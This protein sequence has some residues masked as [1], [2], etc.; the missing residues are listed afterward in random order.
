LH[1]GSEEPRKNIPTL[2]EAF[3]KLIK[4]FPEALLIRVGKRTAKMR[5]FVKIFGVEGSVVYF[6]SISEANL[7]LLYNASDLF[8][9][10]SYHEGF[11]MPVLEAMSSGTP[12]ISTNVSAISEVVGNSGILVNPFDVE[13]LAYQ[14]NQVLTDLNF[15]REL[16]QKAIHRSSE[17][18]WLITARKTWQVYMD[19]L[20]LCHN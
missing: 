19:L 17:F 13:A 8:V 3:S 7:A 4:N 18:D 2:I 12:V 9:F 14:M 11:G 15:R 6:Q 1:V 16:I 5:K 10:P 20:N